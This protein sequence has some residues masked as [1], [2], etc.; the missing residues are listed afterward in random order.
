MYLDDSPGNFKLVC[1][2]INTEIYVK[3]DFN[4]ILAKILEKLSTFH[5]A[6]QGCTI[7]CPRMSRVLEFLHY[8]VSFIEV[9]NHCKVIGRRVLDYFRF[10]KLEHQLRSGLE[11]SYIFAITQFVGF[12]IGTEINEKIS[13]N[14]ET[15]DTVTWK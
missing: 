5:A 7:K 4:R 14:G 6:K 3:L 15:C 11:Q 2:E 13:V 8:S 9:C 10:S 1:R 12:W